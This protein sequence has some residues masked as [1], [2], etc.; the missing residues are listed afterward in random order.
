MSPNRG[1]TFKQFENAQLQGQVTVQIEDGSNMPKTSLGKRAA[2]EQANQLQLLNPQDPDQRYTLL[3]TFGLSDLSPALDAH[4]TTALE[5]QD[6]FEKWA[7][8]MQGPSPLTVKP[9]FDLQIHKNERI[10]WLNT[11]RMRE[12]IQK[13]P[14]LEPLLE[15][16]LQQLQIGLQ[17]PGSFGPGDPGHP[18]GPGG[19]PVTPPVPGGGP[20]MAPGMMAMHKHTSGGQAMTNA[21]KSMSQGPMNPPKGNKSMGPNVGAA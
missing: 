6:A 20:L 3:Q 8:T 7:P 16:H 5:M 9:W 17:P 13:E 18:G 21:N 15:A 2:I 1:Y 11:D 14:N 4:V 10:K 12:L 19:P